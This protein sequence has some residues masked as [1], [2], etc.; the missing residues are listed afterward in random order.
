LLEYAEKDEKPG[1]GEKDSY[2]N[3]VAEAEA[4]I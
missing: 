3:K 1:F 2:K 4:E